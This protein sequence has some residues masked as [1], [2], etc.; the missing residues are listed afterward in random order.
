MIG[1]V[2]KC[3]KGATGLV[4]RT[5]RIKEGPPDYPF[6]FLYIGVCL[7]PGR[8]GQTWESSNPEWV[9]TLSDWVKLRYTE[10][11]ESERLAAIAREAIIA[12]YDPL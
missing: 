7:D 8:E 2:A 6:R 11:A 1:K 4:L 3:Q 5:T 10:I 12:E 9:G